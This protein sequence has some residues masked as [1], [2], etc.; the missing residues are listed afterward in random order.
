MAA[1]PTM[2]GLRA[3]VEGATDAR[4]RLIRFRAGLYACLRRR[5]DALLGSEEHP[6]QIVL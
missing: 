2:P 6:C 3:V 5:G 1:A 4:R